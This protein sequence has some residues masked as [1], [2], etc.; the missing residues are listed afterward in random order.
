MYDGQLPVGDQLPTVVK[1]TGVYLEKVSD[2]L[3][4]VQMLEILSK[5]QDA[6]PTLLSQI[7]ELLT[8]GQQV[9]IGVPLSSMSR[10]FSQFC[11]Y[12]VRKVCVDV[13]EQLLTGHH[14]W[15]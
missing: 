4:N 15:G 14:K 2:L 5:M 9:D 10:L 13:L 11:D 6:V 1:K 8:N 7:C 12:L 3:Y